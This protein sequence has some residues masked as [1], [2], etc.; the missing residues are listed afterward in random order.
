[1]FSL[2][3]DDADLLGLFTFKR[4]RHLGIW[5][6]Q[7]ELSSVRG[8]ISC[9]NTCKTCSAASQTFH[10]NCSGYSDVTSVQMLRNPVR[11][12]QKWSVTL[13]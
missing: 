3:V 10:V 4:E 6:L 2:F 13:T 9:M 11:N 1:M 12:V 7:G 5:L 8:L